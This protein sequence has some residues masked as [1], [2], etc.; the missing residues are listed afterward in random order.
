MNSF[1]E[2]GSPYL[3]HRLGG[4]DNRHD[5]SAVCRREI[6]GLGAAPISRLMLA[7][8]GNLGKLPSITT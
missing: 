2:C 8:L 6:V 4:G 3:W 7:S 5:G 1:L